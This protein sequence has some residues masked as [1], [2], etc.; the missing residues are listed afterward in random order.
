M[1]DIDLLDKDINLDDIYY[2]HFILNIR[3]SFVNHLIVRQ[4]VE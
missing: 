1:Y 2:N 4:Y 3:M